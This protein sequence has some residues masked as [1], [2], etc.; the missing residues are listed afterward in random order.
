M[1]IAV[2]GFIVAIIRF[3]PYPGLLKSRLRFHR[4]LTMGSLRI[5]VVGCI[6]LLIRLRLPGSAHYRKDPFSFANQ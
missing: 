1:R 5:A 6:E 2:N 4:I 3:S